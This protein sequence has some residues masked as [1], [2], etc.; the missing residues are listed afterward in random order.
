MPSGTHPIQRCLCSLCFQ[1][2][3]DAENDFDRDVFPSRNCHD[4]IIY[5]ESVDIEFLISN[6]EMV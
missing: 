2:L 1:D 4:S 3:L 5:L 6:G